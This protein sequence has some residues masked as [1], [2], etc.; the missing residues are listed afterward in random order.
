M[1]IPYY[2]LGLLPT[3]LHPLE[4]LSGL[5]P[6]YRLFI[7]RDDQTGLAMGGNKTRKLE[8]LIHQAL[9]HNSDTVITSG[10]AQS[11]HCRQT[12]AAC[13]KAGLSCHLVLYDKGQDKISGNLLLDRLFGAKLHWHDDGQTVEY[14]TD[15]LR[16]NGAKP[17]IIPIGGS[18]ET[19]C[20][21]Y[22]RAMKELL[23][24]QT[25]TGIRIDHIILPT[26]SGG[27]QAG[28]ILGK[29]IFGI[30]ASI[31]GINI[32]KTPIFDKP[33]EDH[34]LDIAGKA[35]F[36]M[37]LNLTPER[38][39]VTVNRD[40]DKKGYGILTAAEK[41]AIRMMAQEEG[42]LLDP[43]YTGRAFAGLL[44]MLRLH[45]FRPGSAI[46][47]WHTGGTPALFGYANDFSEDFIH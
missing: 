14:V 9:V 15:Q 42:I 27:T 40:Y 1:D 39:D 36:K 47:F 38:R 37:N 21:G 26:S 25:E 23:Q 35:A 34:I 18:N 10:A 45:F 5:F 19:G 12:A 30:H 43:V 41:S 28:M 22:V 11:N 20:L 4:K 32:D 29:K 8:Y 44:D 13:A 17:Y 6:D 33:A 31:I 3:P 16:Q 24:Q 2:P 7:K 46:L